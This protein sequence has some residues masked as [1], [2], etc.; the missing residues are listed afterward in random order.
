MANRSPQARWNADCIPDQRGRLAVITGASSGIGVETARVLAQKNASVVLAVRNVAKGEEVA[1][2]MRQQSASANVTV[3]E[4]ELSSL[5]SITTFAKQLARDYTRVDILVNNAGVMMCPYATTQDGFEIQFGTNHLGHFALTLQLLPLLKN[6]QDS[7]VVNVS[8]LAHKRGKLALDDLNWNRRKYSTVQAYCDSKLAN[9]YFTY[10]MA[11]KLGAEAD[12]PKVTAAHPGWTATDLQRHLGI[13]KHLNPI[14]G[15]SIPMGALP[16][17]RAAFDDDA[18]SGSYFGPE[19]FLEQSGHPIKVRST[20]R[21]HD[22]AAARKL[23]ELSEE[24]TGIRF[25]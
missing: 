25:Q 9:L 13:F 6:A 18:P 7:R 21:S 17:L 8:S 22:T 19:K 11:R 24:M 14:F 16:T 5:A 4:L 10:E 15:Q 12:A 3:R 1:Q 23:W 2:S 20:P